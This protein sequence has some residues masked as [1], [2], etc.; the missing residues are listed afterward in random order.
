MLKNIQLIPLLLGLVIGL[1]VVYLFPP[2]HEAVV[3][4]PTPASHD[5]YRDKNGVCYSFQAEEVSC[6]KFEDKLREFPLQ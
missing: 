3:R 2:E 1:F 4:Y 5:V 6:D